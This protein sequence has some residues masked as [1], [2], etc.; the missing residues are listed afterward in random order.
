MHT[1]HR[2]AGQDAADRIITPA[3]EQAVGLMVA[4]DRQG[5]VV[6]TPRPL[7]LVAGMRVPDKTD[8]TAELAQPAQ[9]RTIIRMLG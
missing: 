1:A 3:G 9:A 2:R 4:G 7:V 8:H 6:I 5:A